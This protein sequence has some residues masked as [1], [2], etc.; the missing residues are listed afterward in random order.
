MLKIRKYFAFRNIDSTSVK[1]L[2]NF[3][4]LEPRI[5]LSAD[6]LLDFI[7][8]DHVQ[9]ILMDSLQE[10]VQ[11]TELPQTHERLEQPAQSEPSNADDYQPILTLCV[12]D[13]ENK[14]ADVDLSI[15]EN[16][17][18]EIMESPAD[19]VSWA[20]A[21]IPEGLIETITTTGSN[22]P[23]YLPSIQVGTS[24]SATILPSTDESSSLINMD[25][26]R[27]D[28]Q[29]TDIDGAGFATVI[30]DTGI[31]V[32]HPFF[33]PDLD[34]DGV[35]DRIVY[36]E[37]FADIDYDASD[38]HG[39]GSNV[40]SIIASSDSTY[41]G[42]APAADIIHLKVFSDT[43]NPGN[44]RDVELA[45]QW[46][47]SNVSTYNI[48]SVNMS[49]GDGNNWS[50]EV[51]L[52]GLGDELAALAAQDVIVVSASGNAFYNYGSSQGVSYPAADP[53]SLSIGAV[54]DSNAGSF[55]YTSGA[56]AHSTDA[57]QIAPFSQRHP[58]LTT[59][60]APGA[61]ITGAG[62]M[63]GTTIFH[64]TSQASPH[65]AGIAVLAQQL[66]QENLGRRLTVNEFTALLQATAV[67][68]KD[69]DDEDDN[70]TNTGLYF[71]R[72][73][74]LA[75]GQA[76]LAMANPGNQ[77]L[78]SEDFNDGNYNGWI[79][80][81]QSTMHGPMA[82]SAATGVMVQSSNVHSPPPHLI[83]KLGTFAYWQAGTSWTDYTTTLTMKSTDNDALGV[84]FR[85]QDENNYYR[86][87]WDKERKSRALVK[88]DDGLFTILAEDS[89]QYAIGQNYQIKISVLGSSLQVSIDGNPVF[90]VIDTTFSSGTI[91]LYSWGNAGSHFDD[92]LVES[93]SG[94]NQVPVISSV[95]A[96]LSTISDSQTSQLQVTATDPDSGPDPLAYSWSAQPGEGSFNDPSIADPIYTPPDVSS[97]QTFTLTV[98]VSDG[99]DTVS[100]TVDI[101]VTD[102][103]APVPQTLLSEDFN[104]GNYNGWTLVEQST[105]GGPMA[106]SVVSGAMVQS[107]NVHSAPPHGTS[108]LGTFAYWQDGTGWTDYTATINMK[109]TDNDALGIMFRYQ[110]ENNYYRFIWD[111]ERKSRALVKCE[112]GLFTILA[113]D[114]VQYAIGQSYQVKISAL[115]SSLQVSIDD[116]P[117]FLVSD[118]T[119][120]SGSIALYSWG[121]AGS[122]FDDILVEAPS[123]VNMAPTI[124][125]VTATPSTISDDVTSQLQVDAID[126]DGGP[127]ALTY[128][129]SAQPGE[130]SFSDPTIADP[131]YTPPNV[132]TPQT[133]TLTVQVSDGD[134]TTQAAVD[135]TVMEDLPQTL[136]SEDFNDGNYND[137]TLVEQSTLGGPMA[138]SA[139]SG[140][141]VQSSNV[142]SAPPHG[143]SKLGT[144]AYWQA[145]I[146][147]TD[148]TATV[149][150]KSTDNDAVGVM[151]RYQD[152]NNYYR[153]IWDKERKS[154]ALVK[155]DDG[156]FTIL[157]EDTIQ[158]AIGQN[159]Q[160]KITA[161]GD[162]LQVSI[163]GSSV[164]SVND[165]TFLSGSIA[166]Y[167]WG[168]EGSHFD[169]IVVESIP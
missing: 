98:D 53:N 60:F 59:V 159:Y 63:G 18:I 151:F 51:S 3:E 47:V 110:D 147:W 144:F 86:F 30:L 127:G 121:N 72:V 97:T 26:F 6:G 71:P 88:C 89:I 102:A 123:G 100:Q 128:S 21:N 34:S 114:F 73:D 35:A 109:S 160:V 125:S 142:H 126:P 132:T 134:A 108:K 168:N 36:Q 158:Y 107:S 167:S 116:S 145:G 20:S 85:Y 42:M 58:T 69:G 19:G 87:I 140:V 7:G 54:Y 115:G 12:N 1:P 119:F 169:D 137:W 24:D 92:I 50:T 79:L 155:C 106:W 113:E 28:M 152:E 84:M 90:S 40:S 39:H 57:D 136:L 153:F 161:Q 61:P 131:V 164:F 16:T 14:S 46:V 143:V 103:S 32:D 56:K 139:A 9:N 55:T 99:A 129:W 117:V 38:V 162:S 44:F 91:A 165:S 141:M 156:V 122:H 118:S 62:L 163:D 31:D 120:S 15:E 68:I 49:L 27:A 37:D 65:I 25:S 77:I 13:N 105:L 166:L 11:C 2:S 130:G 94:A 41:T 157:A 8:P 74:M 76:I 33:G 17:S 4:Q 133:F 29:F 138:W 112:N 146:G 80:V 23:V 70:V 81:A 22:A 154:R 101:T 148:Y 43:G 96:S 135:I 10:V 93:P 150:M 104:D 95:T 149:T 48:V 78:L 5:L 52:Y 67:Q 45:L 82:W 124:S 66:A 75:L 111:K 64:G 83:S